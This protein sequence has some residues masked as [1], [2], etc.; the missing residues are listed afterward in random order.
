MNK[1]VRAFLNSIWVWLLAF[2]LCAF[3]LFACVG[4]A[5]VFEAPPPPPKAS[6]SQ[7]QD[8]YL[9]SNDTTNVLCWYVHE[10]TR[11]WMNV[12]RDRCAGWI[13]L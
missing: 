7:F 5:S 9:R 2:V 11:W 1:Q 13:P 6:K 8:E 10:N 4:C 12:P 3:T